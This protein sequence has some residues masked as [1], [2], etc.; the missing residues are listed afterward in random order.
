MKVQNRS[1]TEAYIFLGKAIL[2][3]LSGGIVFHMIVMIIDYYLMIEPFYLNMRENFTT[4]IFSEPM[5]PMLGVYGL[6]SL[7]IY[8]KGCV[9]RARK[10]ISKR[11]CK[12]C[13]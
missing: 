4:S 13:S 2:V 1:G 5:M 9:G 8:Q 3:F 11:K 7:G 6:L 10:G 12:S